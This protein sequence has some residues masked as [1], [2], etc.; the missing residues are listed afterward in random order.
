MAEN[1]VGSR[2]ENTDSK[3]QFFQ[4]LIPLINTAIG[5]KM[6]D[7]EVRSVAFMVERKYKSGAEPNV[8]LQ[9]TLG[10]KNVSAREAALQIHNCVYDEK[11][12]KLHELMVSISSESEKFKTW[13]EQINIAHTATLDNYIKNPGYI[14]YI[15]GVSGDWVP[16]WFK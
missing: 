14:P 10:V 15:G 16:A 4:S 2:V 7:T 8:F 5:K 11:K 6:D 13:M 9:E 3:V 12:N 1:M